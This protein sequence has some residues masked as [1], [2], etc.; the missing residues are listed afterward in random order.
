[1]NEGLAFQK[2]NGHDDFCDKTLIKISKIAH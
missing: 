1:M 2:C